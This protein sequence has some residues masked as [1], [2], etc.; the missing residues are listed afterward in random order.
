MQP[1]FDGHNDVLMRLW[2]TA[3]K[4]GDPIAE[5]RD[6]IATGHIDGP[7]A[8]AGGLVGGLCAIFVPSRQGPRP[9]FE[10]GRYVSPLAE[11]LDQPAALAA[12]VA[13]AGIARRLDRERA[14]RLCTSTAAIR[15][16]IADGVFAAVLHME[17]CEP[18]DPDLYA[19]DF[20]YAAGLRSLGPVWSRTNVFGHGVPFAYPSS[21]DTGPG[22]TEAGVRLVKA[23]NRLGIMIDL[24]HIT[25]QG[26]WDVAKTSEMPLVATHSNV[27]AITPVTRN[28][29]DRQL[30]AIRETG[31]MVGLNYATSF[32][33]PDGQENAATPLTDMV[34]HVDHLVEHLGI[35]GVGLGSDY[36]GATIPSEIGDAA[37]QQALVGALRQAGYGE[38][39]LVKLC[40]DNWLRVLA[41]TWRE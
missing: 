40:R 4:G 21:P 22:L 10:Q 30:A 11:P 5:F 35:D 15:Q 3:G 24:S 32:L 27:H 18:I 28:L 29:T 14:W 33:R 9:T 38:A 1:V 41:T 39:D 6:G 8:Q 34:R 16:A 26:F 13:M 17:G 12:A 23:C 2:E 31:G 7:R 36:D 19:L 20:F 37:G 25:E